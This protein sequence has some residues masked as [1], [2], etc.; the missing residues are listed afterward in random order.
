MQINKNARVKAG[1]LIVGTL[2]KVIEETDE[3]GFVCILLEDSKPYKT[4]DQVNLDK[5]EFQYVG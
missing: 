5:W 1:P 3:E 4:G 2:I